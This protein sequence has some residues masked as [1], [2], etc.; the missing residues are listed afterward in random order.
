MLR[1]W[2]DF[3]C[4]QAVRFYSKHTDGQTETSSFNNIMTSRSGLHCAGHKRGTWA[5]LVVSGIFGYFGITLRVSLV[6]RRPFASALWSV[7]HF[8]CILCEL[9]SVCLFFCICC[10]LWSVCL[11]F[12]S[13]V[14]ASYCST[15][16][17]ETVFCCLGHLLVVVCWCP[18]SVLGVP[19]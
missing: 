7:C 19:C 9:W 16:D 2:L 14:T 6:R 10:G 8:F 1:P 13:F 17:Q 15:V 4:S 11:F 3:L 5:V 12:D 18:F